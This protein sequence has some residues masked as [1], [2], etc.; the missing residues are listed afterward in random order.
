MLPLSYE[1]CTKNN[2]I[3][4]YME[5]DKDHIHYMIETEPTISI[6]KVVNLIKGYTTYHIG[7]KHTEHLKNHF[8]KEH[9]FWT[10]GY[11]ACSVGNVS[12]EMLKQYIENQG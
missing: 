11:F 5:T 8:W 9:T 2:I 7:E 1:I 10:D 4:K 3:I 6:S 12:E